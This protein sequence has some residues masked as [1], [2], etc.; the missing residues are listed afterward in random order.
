MNKN[1]SFAKRCNRLILSVLTTLGF[2]PASAQVESQKRYDK[3]EDDDILQYYFDEDEE[4]GFEPSVAYGCPSADFIFRGNVTDES[5]KA[6]PDVDVE[7]KC[8][9]C[10]VALMKTDESGSFNITYTDSPWCDIKISFSKDANTLVD[11]TILL[12]DIVFEDLR[13][14]DVWYCGK[15]EADMQVSL[16]KNSDESRIFLNRPAL[17]KSVDKGSEMFRIVNPVENYMWFNFR[18]VSAADVTIT[19][20]SGRTLKHER[21]NDGT[22]IYVGDLNSGEYVVTAVSGVNRFSALFIKK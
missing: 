22:N 18:N 3:T 1:K 7:V 4:Y 8:C 20:I 16:G 10:T 9:D 11:T 12:S 13:E 14:G 21:V 19:D 5:G 2:L 15:Y 6:I 17:S